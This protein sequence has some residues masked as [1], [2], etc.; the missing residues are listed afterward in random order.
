MSYFA[1]V[2]HGV[3]V[4]YAGSFAEHLLVIGQVGGE[5]FEVRPQALS[6]AV[7]SWT[8]CDAT[9]CVARTS[10]AGL[11]L[12]ESRQSRRVNPA[13][14]REAALGIGKLD[15]NIGVTQILGLT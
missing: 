14:P 8:D 2:Q 5:T 12:C 9:R 15:Q 6:G 11:L 4:Q 1:E 7:E 13:R 3:F 10:S